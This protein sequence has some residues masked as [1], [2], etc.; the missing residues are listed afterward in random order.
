MIETVSGMRCWTMRDRRMTW[1]R[2][3]SGQVDGLTPQLPLHE[4]M[5]RLCHC[6]R[7]RIN[8]RGLRLIELAL[9]EAETG[10]ERHQQDHTHNT[11]HH[12]SHYSTH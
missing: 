9:T 8:Q 4:L 7:G 5:G 2:R 3:C 12:S 6:H 1:D 11:P 10:D